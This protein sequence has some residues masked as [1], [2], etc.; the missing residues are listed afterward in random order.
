MEE[1]RFFLA[2]CSVVESLSTSQ[3]F[4][5]STW[6]ERGWCRLERVCQELSEEEPQRH[7][8]D[9]LLGKWK[10]LGSHSTVAT[11]SKLVSGSTITRVV[12][13]GG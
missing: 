10:Q 5:P 4:T 2:L 12:E 7:Q 3:L 11:S 6:F 13:I 1:C 9:A 8:N